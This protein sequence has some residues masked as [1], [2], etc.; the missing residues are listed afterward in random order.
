VAHALVRTFFYCCEFTLG[1]KFLITFFSGY[2]RECGIIPYTTDVDIGVFA[3]D[4]SE[5]IVKEFLYRGFYLK[6][7]FGKPN[8]SYELSFVS[9]G[10]KVDLF[11]FY[12][13]GD[14][15]WNGGTQRS[16]G[17]KFK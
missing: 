4:Y 12:E 8:D 5:N 13:E 15:M 11:F 6:H 17:K 1:V 3:K 10:V 16:S 7:I 2:F 9:N 14:T